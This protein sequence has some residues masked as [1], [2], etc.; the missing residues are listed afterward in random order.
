MS[1]TETTHQP[2]ERAVQCG[3]CPPG[4]TTWNVTA[5]CDAHEA[6]HGKRA[7]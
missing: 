1:N 2:R 3:L 5:L 6:Q 4:R 7:A